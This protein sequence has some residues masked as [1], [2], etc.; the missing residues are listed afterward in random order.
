MSA[1][2]SAGSRVD[3]LPARTSDLT[4][5]RSWWL[6]CRAARRPHVLLLWYLRHD[7]PWN[8]MSGL[9]MLHPATRGGRPFTMPQVARSIWR[10]AGCK[11]RACLRV[12]ARP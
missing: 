12:F 7:R 1:S 9:S 11:P 3:M 10:I 5:D 2:Y 8:Y 6:T 4:M